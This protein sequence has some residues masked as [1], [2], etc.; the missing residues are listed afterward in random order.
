MNRRLK[1]HIY[2][3]FPLYG[4]AL[5]VS[6]CLWTWLVP[7]KVAY[8]KAE[9]I[10]IFAGVKTGNEPLFSSV[11]LS[12]CSGVK[13]VDVYSCD[14]SDSYF[15]TMVGSK[16]RYSCDFF[17]LPLGSFEDS[18]VQ[19]LCAPLKQEDLKSNFGGDYDYFLIE[20]RTYGFKLYKEETRCL[21]SFLTYGD[22]ATDQ[23]LLLFNRESEN[24]NTLLQD[25]SGKTSNAVSAVKALFS[26]EG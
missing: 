13:Q 10:G 24:L 7:S 26:Y 17:L 11:I 20:G 4:V 6:I 25:R 23:Y 18:L 14:P 9:K 21:S 15:G 19:S 5:A 3:F 2:R 8:T 16:G 22:E 1:R 12:S